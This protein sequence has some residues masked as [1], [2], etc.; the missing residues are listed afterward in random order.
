LA[1]DFSEHYSCIQKAKKATKKQEFQ[2][3]SCYI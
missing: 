3:G 1:K 2:I